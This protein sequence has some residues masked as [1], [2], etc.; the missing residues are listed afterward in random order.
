MSSDSQKES[1]RKFYQN[2]REKC[3]ADR[4]ARRAAGR[5]FIQEQKLAPCMDCLKAFGH[6]QMQ[7]DHVSGE[8]L[9]DIANMCSFSKEKILEEIAKCELV[10]ANCHADRTYRRLKGI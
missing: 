6:W 5:K 4:K 10:C 8:K 3:V 7:F 9:R 1:Q 2:N